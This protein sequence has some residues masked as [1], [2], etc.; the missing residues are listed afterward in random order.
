M[1]SDDERETLKKRDRHH[2][3][4]KGPRFDASVNDNDPNGGLKR[5]N[6]PPRRKVQEETLD[7]MQEYRNNRYQNIICCKC[8]KQ[9]DENLLLCDGECNHL[10][11]AH[12]SCLKLT[13][14]P[15][16]KW[17]CDTCQSRDSQPNQQPVTT[18]SKGTDINCPCDDCNYILKDKQALF[19]HVRK[20]HH[21]TAE[22]PESYYAE[23]KLQRC[24]TCKHGYRSLGS[25]S[26][27]CNKHTPKVLVAQLQVTPTHQ[28]STAAAA[29]TT[30]LLLSSLDSTGRY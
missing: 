8:N 5:P 24:P 22:V 18:T 12:M 6:G 30:P 17:F 13:N 9:T 19:V 7:P 29:T 21:A 20:E 2:R 4:K 11:S 26:K 10:G 15:S 16:N 1:I 3:N 25:H 28:P 27:A 23:Y 14:E